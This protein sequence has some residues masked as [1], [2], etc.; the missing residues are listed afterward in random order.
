LEQ[1]S[2]GQARYEKGD[3]YNTNG[4]LITQ[5]PYDSKTILIIGNWSEIKGSTDLEQKIKE[6]T[7]ELFRRDSRN[8]EIL[9]YDELYEKARFIVDD[10]KP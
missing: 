7:F 10:K 8:V 9:T 6:K 4:D 5:K 2:S 3:I 1:K